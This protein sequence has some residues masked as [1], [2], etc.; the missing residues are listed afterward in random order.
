MHDMSIFLKQFRNGEIFPWERSFTREMLNVAVPIAVHSMFMA[1]LHIIDNVMI[2]QL[3]EVELAAVTQANRVTFL[4]QLT[5][6]GLYG[7]TATFIAQFWGKRD[8]KGIHATMGLALCASL[9]LAFCFV[10]PCVLFP[11]P[12]MRLLLGDETAVAVATQYLPII[13]VGYLTM[14]VS[15]CYHTVQKSTEQA[16]LPMLAGIAALVTN[17]FLNYCFIFGNFGFPRLGARGGALATVIA[18]F[19][20]LLIVV[21]GGYAL[22]FATAARPARGAGGNH[23]VG[24]VW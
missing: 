17:T 12:L 8:L 5:L 22:H 1:L 15:E 13:A 20:D 16:R 19:V 14:S 11:A 9:L 3:G 7:G 10:I 6:F 23:T 2:G 21:I 4:F 24:E 18:G